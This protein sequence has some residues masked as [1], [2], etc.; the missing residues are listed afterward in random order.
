MVQDRFVEAP[1]VEDVRLRLVEVASVIDPTDLSA[2]PNSDDLYVAGRN[3]FVYRLPSSGGTKRTTEVALDISDKVD[4]KNAEHGHGGEPG[5]LALAFSPDGDRLYVTYTGPPP[6]GG[7]GVRWK[8]V[9]FGMRGGVVD[10]R[11]E[12]ELIAVTKEFPH[13]N[14]GDIA[15]GPDGYLYSSLG[16]GTPNGDANQ[17]GQDPSDL[18]G[19]MWRIDPSPGGGDP[20]SIP[21]DN[22]FVD[23]GGAPEVWLYGMRNPWRFSFDQQTG[24][25]WLPDVGDHDEEEINV[26]RIDEG[27]GRGANLGW[28][29][30]EGT[31]LRGAAPPRNHEPPVFTYPHAGTTSCAVIGGYVYRGSAIPGLR[32]AFLFSDYCA[33]ELR[34]LSYDGRTTTDHD[35]GLSVPNPTAFGQG[36]DGEI[37]VLSIAG[38]IFRI[39]ERS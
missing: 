12:R 38:G 19:S 20:Y 23:G 10:P 14:G 11:T 6:D 39:E 30:V 35:L 15:F 31:K 16:D 5:L 24:D 33:G 3:G 18:F 9:E 26:L 22:P 4:T 27:Y 36:Q 21:G 8:L 34:A 29:L 7:R 13:H 1:R 32:G 17:T 2:H 28:S 25:L 37:Y